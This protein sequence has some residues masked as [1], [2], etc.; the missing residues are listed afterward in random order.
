[1]ARP[2]YFADRDHAFGAFEDAIAS[3]LRVSAYHDQMGVYIKALDT[4]LLPNISSHEAEFATWLAFSVISNPILSYRKSV[5]YFMVC[6][7]T[8]PV[9]SRHEPWFT[10][11]A[12]VQSVVDTFRT[13]LVLTLIS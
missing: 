10:L 4:V 12:R 2:T 3:L 1:M 8:G 5:A 13:I 11:C 9:G 7:D 6:G